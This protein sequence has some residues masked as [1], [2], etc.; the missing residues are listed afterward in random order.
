MT[1]TTSAANTPGADDRPKSKQLG[2]LRALLPFFGPYRWPVI[3]TIVA[4]LISAGVSLLLPV[5][6]RRVIDSF[7]ADVALL[8]N[9]F[10][11]AI[12]V[13]AIF[14]ASSAVRFYLV[15]RLGERVV[16][17]IRK[18]V[19]DRMI[20]MSPAYFERLMTGEILS[21]I[22]TDTTLILSVVGSSLSWFMRN[23]LLLA[24]GLVMMLFTSLKLTGLVLYRGQKLRP[25][26]EGGI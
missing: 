22:T 18:A 23:I 19:F 15:T 10:A 24:G 17:D 9:Y 2:V 4:L 25:W 16:A 20:G 7:G 11:A 8:N 14:A 12:G 13:A 26:K 21:R 1:D 3:A 6:A 5:A